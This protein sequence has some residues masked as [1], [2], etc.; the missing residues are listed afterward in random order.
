MRKVTAHTLTAMS[1][2]LEVLAK[3]CLEQIVY[4]GGLL[5]II[6]GHLA[7]DPF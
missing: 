5:L 3:L 6:G 7:L 1:C 4:F 2:L